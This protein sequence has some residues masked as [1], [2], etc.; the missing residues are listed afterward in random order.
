ML[1]LVVALS[2]TRGGKIGIILLSKYLVAQARCV[3]CIVS[4]NF[5]NIP[6]RSLLKIIK[7]I[8]EANTCNQ[9][10]ILY[11]NLTHNPER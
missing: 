4:L 2:G 5:G 8:K 3:V 6:M 7:V 11:L 1:V 10:L 9:V